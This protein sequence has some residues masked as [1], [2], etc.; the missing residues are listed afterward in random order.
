M[1]AGI[2]HPQC[3]ENLL[4]HDSYPFIYKKMKNYPVPIKSISFIILFW[5]I[6]LVL[7]LCRLLYPFSVELGLYVDD[8]PHGITALDL[9]HAPCWHEEIIRIL[10]N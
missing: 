9:I 5:H 4:D 7:A 1:N 10:M 2:I 8:P 6:I 3:G